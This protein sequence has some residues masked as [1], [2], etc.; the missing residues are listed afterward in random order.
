MPEATRPSSRGARGS[1]RRTS[2]RSGSPPGRTRS[3]SRT[4]TRS[5][6]GTLAEAGWLTARVVGA[7]WWDGPAATTDRGA[8]RAARPG[9][10]AR[11]AP[12]SV[13][14]MQDGVIEN[15]SGRCSSRTSDPRR[16][17]ERPIAGMSLID[18]GGSRRAVTRL[19]A[20]GFQP[21][22]HAIGD[23]AVR[24]ASMPSRRPG[25]QR[26]VGHA[27]AHRPH[28]G[29]PSR[30]HR[31]A[32]RALDVVA[33]AQPLLG[34]PRGPD[35]HADD[36]VP[37]AGASE[38]A[39]PV[40]VAAG[41]RGAAGDGLGLERLDG[42]TRCSRSRSRSRGSPI[43]HAGDARRRS[44]RT[45]G[46]TRS[47]RSAAFTSGRPTSTTS[48]PRPARSRSA[49]LADLAVVDRDLFAAAPGR[50]ARPGF[51]RRSSMAPRSTRPRARRADPSA[52]AR[53]TD[54]DSQFAAGRRW[55]AAGRRVDAPDAPRNRSGQRKGEIQ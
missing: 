40:P 39:V 17:P 49:R 9:R 14:L 21:H 37:R 22:F 6:Y 8:G 15:D 32:S 12:T 52:V 18:P 28:P 27:A 29:D 45:S 10:S 30:R 48:T 42:R 53:W 5:A 26:P 7:L 38:L 33:N 47:R 36:P 46:S 2:T 19:D 1:P 41:G 24:E 50:S 13:K 51:S 44:C 25:G 35:G 16:P 31:R 4:R 55:S 11:Y 3:S 34:L 23:R 43:S 20:A 54:D